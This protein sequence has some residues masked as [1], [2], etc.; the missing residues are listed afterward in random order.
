MTPRVSGGRADDG[1][2]VVMLIGT[3]LE[4]LTPEQAE[5]LAQELLEAVEYCRE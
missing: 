4:I 1:V 2:P 3:G 5:E